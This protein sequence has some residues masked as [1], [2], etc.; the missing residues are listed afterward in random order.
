MLSSALSSVQQIPYCFYNG[1]EW[2]HAPPVSGWDAFLAYIK[3]QHDMKD[4]KFYTVVKDELGEPYDRVKILDDREFQ[5]ALQLRKQ[6]FLY[7]GAKG[8][9]PRKG[10]DDLPLYVKTSLRPMG[11]LDTAGGASGHSP[12]SGSP[13]SSSLQTELAEQV[14]ARDRERCVITG[15]SNR[16]QLC[17]ACHILASDASRRRISIDFFRKL[18]DPAAKEYLFPA[19]YAELEHCLAPSAL[20]H[21]HQLAYP[22]RAH[23]LGCCLT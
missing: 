12:S 3:H 18:R 11:S 13:K 7:E 23:L 14:K 15:I 16:K 2:F 1:T 19:A 10:K 22:R 6:L 5:G 17:R 20:A 9:S 8:I 4:P 21:T